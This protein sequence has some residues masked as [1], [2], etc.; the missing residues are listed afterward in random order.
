MARWCWLGLTP[1]AW[2]AANGGA[3]SP[4]TRQA[5]NRQRQARGRKYGATS[6]VLRNGQRVAVG[7]FEPSDLRAAWRCPDAKLVLRPNIVVALKCDPTRGHV[8]DILLD[9]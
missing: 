4:T 8:A 5:R 3:G 6:D 9:L 1:P 7:V 2:M